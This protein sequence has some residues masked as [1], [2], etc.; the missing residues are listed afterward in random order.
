MLGI[1]GK[2]LWMYAG[3]VIMQGIVHLQV[4][5]E[6]YAPKVFGGNVPNTDE[7]YEEG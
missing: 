1:H 6:V 5:M 3:N 7:H 4:D 2:T